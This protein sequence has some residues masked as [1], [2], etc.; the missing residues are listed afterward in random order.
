M[1]KNK[2]E[3]TIRSSTA[4]YLTY[5]AS[6]GDDEKTIEVRYQDENIW[7]TQKMMAELYGVSVP[8]INEHIKKIFDDKELTEDSVIRNFRITASDG[9]SYST[10][11][12]NLQMI[13]AVGFKVNNERAVQ[14]RKWANSIVKDYT[15]QGWAMD[16][17]RLKK[18]GSIL[19]RD[20]FEKQLERIR[21]IRLSERLFYQKITDI[22]ATAIDY[23]P[24]S[25]ITQRF[26]SAVQNKLHYSVHGQTA[27]EL[28]YNRA[29]AEKENM[30]L[31]SWDGSPNSKIHKYDVVV[32]K[33]YLTEQELSQLGRIVSAYLDMAE[34]QAERNI[35]M[36]MEDWEQRL[37]GFLKLWDRDVL[38]D[39][40]KI[41]A[42]L[43]KAKAESEF[44]KYRIVQDRLYQSDFD[45]LLLQVKKD[46]NET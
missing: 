45:K 11:H 5:I 29:D 43:A 14:F 1:K 41:S 46:K 6:V 15:I 34:A 30:G 22:Y 19:T 40:G 20:Y 17:E 23:D 35:P 24:T 21:E 39:N 12:Y 38:Q 28:I 9:K 33:N 42:E 26:F 10:K 4:E 27:A 18:G 13:I 25:K 3:I 44:E 32:A 31:T 36:T 2:Q 37:N 16:D 8:T 7:L